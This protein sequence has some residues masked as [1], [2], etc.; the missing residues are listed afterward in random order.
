MSCQTYMRALMKHT[1]R[2]RVSGCA[3]LTFADRH[4]VFVH[5]GRVKADAA[6]F[7]SMTVWTVCLLSGSVRASTTAV[8]AVEF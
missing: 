1:E 7:R 6:T 2:F 3:C 8:L 5:L 4:G